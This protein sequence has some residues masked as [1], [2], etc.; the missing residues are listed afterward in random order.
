MPLKVIFKTPVG[1]LVHQTLMP[2]AHEFAKQLDFLRNCDVI[3]VTA[4]DDETEMDYTHKYLVNQFKNI[5]VG[6]KY[7]TE[8]RQPWASFILDN[9]ENI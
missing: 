7:A 8:W 4:Y 3:S 1:E 6:G 5:P 2:S 9:I